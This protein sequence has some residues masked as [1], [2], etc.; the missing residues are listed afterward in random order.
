MADAARLENPAWRL[1]ASLQI[2]SCLG[3]SVQM[4][5]LRLSQ[6]RA[7]WAKAKVTEGRGIQEAAG[8]LFTSSYENTGCSPIRDLKMCYRSAAFCSD[9]LRTLLMSRGGNLTTVDSLW[10]PGRANT[11]GTACWPGLPVHDDIGIQSI[12]Q[13]VP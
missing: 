12:I 4:A 13:T 7:I 3:L 9:C 11:D 1:G 8:A 2:S 10:F 6:V 5:E